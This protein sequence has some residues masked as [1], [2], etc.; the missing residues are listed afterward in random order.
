M[1]FPRISCSVC[2]AVLP[3]LGP[4]EVHTSLVTHGGDTRP[5]SHA[6]ECCQPPWVAV[7]SGG[8][9][10]HWHLGLERGRPER[11]RTRPSKL[12]RRKPAS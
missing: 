3:S 12:N 8:W 10:W 9:H 11:R 7:T 1:S 4:Y 6:T 2:S 5:D